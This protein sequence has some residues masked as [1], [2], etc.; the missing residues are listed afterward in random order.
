MRGLI[1]RSERMKFPRKTTWW[2][3]SV[4]DP[5]WNCQG[6]GF[7]NA[8]VMPEEATRKIAELED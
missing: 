1:I 7:A 6:L 8:A 2:F 4:S 5:R 3:S